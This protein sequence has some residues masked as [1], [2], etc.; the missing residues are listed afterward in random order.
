M[1]SHRAANE[2]RNMKGL[3][4]LRFASFRHSGLDPESKMVDSGSKAGMT[5]YRN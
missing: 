3:L 1:F 4:K 5:G 2:T